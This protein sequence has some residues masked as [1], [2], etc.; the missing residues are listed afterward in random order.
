MRQTFQHLLLTRPADYVLLVEYNRPQVANA[1]N[2]LMGDEQCEVFESLYIDQED[3]RCVVLTGKGKHFS[4]GADLKERKGM[5][6]ADWQRQHAKFERGA[7]AIKA[8]PVPIIAAVNGSA[9]GGGC[10]TA[11]NCDFIY[12]SSTAKFALTEITLGIIPGTMGTQH[13]CHAAGE[14]RAK[15]IILTGHAFTA[16][17][18]F[19]WGIVNKVCTPENLIE[20][21]LTTAQRIASNA[22][23]AVMR[24]KRSV[25]IARHTDIHTGYQYELE[26]YNRLVGTEDRREGVLAYNEKRQPNFKGK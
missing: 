25:S 14:R 20:E 2:T 11:L 23:L 3:I 8:C 18:A 22:P 9:Y 19:G 24:A 21:A 6:D 1:K 5:S 15:E 16:E 17:E 10:E 12:A 26:A 7:L 4:A 13:L